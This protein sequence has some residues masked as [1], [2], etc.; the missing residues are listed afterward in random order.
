MD[1]LSSVGCKDFLP[2]DTLE[3]QSL[4]GFCLLITRS[5]SY[6]AILFAIICVVYVLFNRLVLGSSILDFIYGAK[7]SSM[8]HAEKRTFRLRHIGILARTTS[9]L[10]ILK[11]AFMVAFGN[12]EWSEPYAQGSN[13]LLGDA[14]FFSVMI[15]AAFHLFELVFDPSLKPL[16]VVHHLGS[17]FV[18]QGFLPSTVSLP[19]AQYLELNRALGMMN[20]AL[21]WAVLDAPL[22]VLSY[23]I[24][25]LRSTFIQGHTNVCKLFYIGFNIAAFLTVT[26]I[27]V[28][29]YLCSQNWNELAGFQRTTIC[30]LQILF[31]IAKGWV[32]K[33]F[34]LS[35]TRQV[36]T[37]EGKASRDT[38]MLKPE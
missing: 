31:T 36:G 5:S 35:Y 11:P 26:E 23:V 21:Y 24:A 20:V 15:T 33:S 16:L 22:V 1:T 12:K 38:A 10:L 18:I 32:C 7:Y 3:G 27:V 25:V 19:K 2:A 37:L 13:V 14:A 30:S 34:Y 4:T 29:S 28:I 8:R 9:F 17:I 6:D